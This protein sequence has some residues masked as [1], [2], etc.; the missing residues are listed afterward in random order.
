MIR[1]T[2]AV[3]ILAAVVLFGVA[4]FD[5]DESPTHVS[6]PAG[7]DY[8]MLDATVTQ[9]DQ[10]GDVRYR[11][12]SDKSLHFP[13]DSVRLTNILVHYRGGELG[14]WVLKSPHGFVPPDSRD[15]LLTGDVILRRAQQAP[16]PLTITTPHIWVRTQTGLAETSAIVRAHSPGRRVR[17]NGLTVEFDEKTLTLHHD[18][19][20]TFTP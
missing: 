6:T 2:I 9:F 12:T 16:N 11:L 13:N 15:I 14:D 20:V 4:V 3:A 10:H 7:S 8:Y 19:H 18:V 1:Q 5:H 17:S